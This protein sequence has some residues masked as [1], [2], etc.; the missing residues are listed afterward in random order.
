MASGSQH[1]ADIDKMAFVKE[2]CFKKKIL[3]F[4]TKCIQQILY[5]KDTWNSSYAAA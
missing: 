4:K 2:N 5:S 3:S 1:V